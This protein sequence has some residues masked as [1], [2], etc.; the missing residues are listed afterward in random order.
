LQLLQSTLLVTCHLFCLLN[1]CYRSHM[2]Y[3]MFEPYSITFCFSNLHS[4]AS[5]YVCS[6]ALF[7]LLSRADKGEPESDHSFSDG[8]KVIKSTVQCCVCKLFK[9]IIL[10][11]LDID[12]SSANSSAATY[13]NLIRRKATSLY[14]IAP[15]RPILRPSLY[16]K[17]GL[18]VRA[19]VIYLDYVSRA[20]PTYNR[21]TDGGTHNSSTSPPDLHRSYLGGTQSK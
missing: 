6:F 17:Y 13:F 14:E 19:R 11:T 2:C 12:S 9:K 18:S 8:N 20:G 21:S 7:L 5:L 4:N 3:V 10:C 1:F 15:M 16:A